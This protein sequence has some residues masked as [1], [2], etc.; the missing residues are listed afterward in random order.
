VTTPTTADRRPAARR[1]NTLVLVTAILVL[2]V[3]LATAFLVRSQSGRAQAAAEQKATGREH[4]VEAVAAEIAQ[5]VAD[6]LFVRRID[7]SSLPAQVADNQ[8]TGLAGQPIFGEFLARSDYPRLPPEPLAVR[9]GVDYVDTVNNVSLAAAAGGDGFID[10]YNY[11]PFAT[12]PFTNW[13]ARYRGI[14]GEGNPN[15]N[16]GFGDTRWLASTEPVRALTVSQAGGSVANPNWSN[17]ALFPVDA[18]APGSGVAPRL[19]P[20]GLGFSHWAHLSWIATADNGFRLCW[21]ISDVEAN[22][23]HLTVA[24]P[25]PQQ[26]AVAGELNLGVPY[27]QWLPYVPPREPRLLGKDARGYLVLDPNDWLSRRNQWF[28]VGIGAFDAANP[29]PHQAIST[30]VPNAARRFDALPNFLQLSAFGTP[31]DEFKVVTGPQPGVPTGA[32]PVGSPTPRSLIAR[33]LAD[34]DGDGW[35]DSFWFVAPTSSDR[36]TR[37]LVAV[38]IMDNSALLNVNV[39]SRFERTNTSRSPRVGSR[40]RTSG[41]RPPSEGW[42]PGGTPRSDS[43]TRP[44][45]TP[46]SAL[47]G[48]PRT[49]RRSSL[50]PPS[51][52][53]TG[54]STSGSCPPAGKGRGRSRRRPQHPA[55]SPR[56]RDSS[57]SSRRLPRASGASRSRSSMP[58]P[59]LGSGHRRPRTATPSSSRAPPIA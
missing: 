8:A 3:I 46:S 2:L 10:G 36:S 13:P 27:E 11:A 24:N 40:T 52:S 54:T 25:S 9:Y 4:R 50:P 59:S 28:N 43:S 1:A 30:G 12:F 26:R 39:A 7:P 53:S 38:R 6:A 58:P 51:R 48:S 19:S 20:E 5:H 34:A 14:P 22:W 31:A 37:Q 35:T 56:S 29:P 42:R 21:D 18:A 15:G 45:T 49:C 23:D 41:R 47:A 44:T 16:P 55:C 32:Y 17:L 33:T 57:A